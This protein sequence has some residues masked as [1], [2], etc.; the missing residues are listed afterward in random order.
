MPTEDRSTTNKHVTNILTVTETPAMYIY[1]QAD[2]GWQPIISSLL[3][4]RL[5][6]KNVSE[7]TYFVL[8]GM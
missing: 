2:D 4:K 3:A 5:A 6:G 1:M 7:M 8:S